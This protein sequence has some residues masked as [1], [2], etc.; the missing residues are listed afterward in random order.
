MLQSRETDLLKFTLDKRGYW[1]H[2][3]AWGRSSKRG[4]WRQVWIEHCHRSYLAALNE[5]NDTGAA[6]FDWKNQINVTMMAA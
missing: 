2:V 5:Y 4:A 1:Y 3:N 6:M